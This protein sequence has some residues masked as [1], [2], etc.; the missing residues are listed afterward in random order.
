[1][2]ED[3]VGRFCDV[4]Y[5]RLTG[6]EPI[7]KPDLEDLDVTDEAADTEVVIEQVKGQTMTLNEARIKLGRE[8]DERLG[9]LYLAE[10]IAQFGGGGGGGAGM[11]AS[12]EPW[13]EERKRTAG[14]LDDLATVI[15][16]LVDAENPEYPEPSDEHSNGYH[17][18]LPVRFG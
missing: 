3:R 8:R 14:Y 12:V 13:G 10:F 15:A 6:Q 18:E 16:R 9:D 2:I 4:E 5:K 1:L 11:G 17:A 7:W